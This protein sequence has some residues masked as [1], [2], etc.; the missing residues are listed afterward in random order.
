MKVVASFVVLIG[1]L[2][3]TERLSPLV[4]VVMTYDRSSMAD[5]LEGYGSLKS[6]VESVDAYFTLQLVLKGVVSKC[7]PGHWMLPLGGMRPQLQHLHHM[8]CNFYGSRSPHC[9]LGSRN[10]PSQ[11]NCL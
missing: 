1:R 6:I 8:L 7:H 4:A 11:R 5:S 10:L 9:V 2:L 3:A